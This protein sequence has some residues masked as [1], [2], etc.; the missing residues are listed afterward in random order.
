MHA[1]REPGQVNCCGDAVVKRKRPSRAQRQIDESGD[2]VH[3]TTCKIWPAGSSFSC[4]DARRLHLSC[5]LLVTCQLAQTHNQKVMG[6]LI[7]ACMVAWARPTGREQLVQSLAKFLRS[8]SSGSR[9][10]TRTQIVTLLVARNRWIGRSGCRMCD[11]KVEEMQCSVR[12]DRTHRW[13]EK[14]VL[15]S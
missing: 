4:Y 14:D 13:R 6:W 1:C 7:H 12:T 9:G 3:R 10:H 15:G 2:A 5:Y 8:A 11:F